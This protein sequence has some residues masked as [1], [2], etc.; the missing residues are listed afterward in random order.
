[1]YSYTYNSEKHFRYE[2]TSKFFPGLTSRARN[3]FLTPSKATKTEEEFIEYM[4]SN[5]LDIFLD[6]E[7][8]RFH[9]YV[10]HSNIKNKSDNKYNDLRFRIAIINLK[11][12]PLSRDGLF[13]KRIEIYNETG[14]Y[15]FVLGIRARIGKHEYNRYYAESEIIHLDIGNLIRV[16]NATKDYKDGNSYLLT[17]EK[18]T[19]LFDTGFKVDEDI[20]CKIDLICLSH[21]H[22]DHS[23]GIVDAVN[24][25]HAPII[26]SEATLVYLWEQDD[27]S[28]DE[29]I[30]ITRKTILIDKLSSKYKKSSK[31]DWFPVFHCP[32]SYGFKYTDGN[33]STLYYLNIRTQQENQYII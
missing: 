27:I 11:P 9:D 17:G 33:N 32:G 14:W 5:Y 8:L 30:N 21:F 1:M 25:F 28:M 26:M 19:I 15:P 6:L 29:K 2:K 13:N 7:W 31:L 12:N 18:G 20:T 16:E 22:K 24:R 3:A 23:A 4:K 10:Y